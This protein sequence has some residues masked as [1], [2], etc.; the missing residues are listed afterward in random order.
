MDKITYVGLMIEPE[1]KEALRHLAEASGCN[2][3]ELLRTWIEQC[4]EIA[5][6]EDAMAAEV[7]RGE[8]G[9]EVVATIE[10]LHIRPSVFLEKWWA[11]HQEGEQD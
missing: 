5:K 10:S 1:T 11:A 3:S 9:P 4:L 8:L 6:R 7:L 2:L